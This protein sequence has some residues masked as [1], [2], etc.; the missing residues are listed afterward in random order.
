MEHREPTR[1]RPESLN[2]PGV[3][4][5]FESTVAKMVTFHRRSGSVDG[6]LKPM[7]QVGTVVVDRID[8]GSYRVAANGSRQQVNPSDFGERRLVFGN[9]DIVAIV[10][11]VL[12][13]AC[14]L[15]R[16]RKTICKYVQVVVRRS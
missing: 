7:L 9:R 13:I 12:L 5:L 1:L 6:N 14:L 16:H 2:F 11:V 8:G 10:A 4:L 15:F 3:D